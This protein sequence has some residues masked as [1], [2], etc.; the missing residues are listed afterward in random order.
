VQ[1]VSTTLAWAPDPVHL[2]RARSWRL[3]PAV[4]GAGLFVDLGSHMLDLLAHYFGPITEVRGQAG[5]RG[6]LYPVEDTVAGA[7]TFASGVEGVGL[8]SFVSGARIDRTEILGNA[9]RISFAC[10]DAG[11][12][13]VETAAGRQELDIA[14]PAHVHQ[15]LIQTVVDELLGRGRCPSDGVSGA[16]TTVVMDRLLAGYR[17]RRS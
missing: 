11:P 1:A 12:V 17:A 14:H 2:D 13:V 8:W 9:G 3:D 16:R 7:F 6:G 10:F 5:N 4:A 15:P